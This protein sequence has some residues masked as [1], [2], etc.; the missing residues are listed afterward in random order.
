MRCLSAQAPA[1][2]APLLC[3]LLLTCTPAGAADTLKIE[4]RT[5]VEATAERVRARVVIANGGTAPAYNLRVHLTALGVSDAS[6]VVSRLDPGRMEGVSFKRD[7]RGMPTGRYPMTVRVDFHDANQYPFS[8]LSGMT[9]DVGEPVNPDL[10]VLSRD[11]E[12]QGS[13]ILRFDLKNLGLAPARITAT[14]VLPKELSSPA[15][16]KGFEMGPRSEGSIGFEVRNFSALPGAS[17]PVFSY[18]EYDSEGVHH[19][20]LGRSLITIAPD[21]TLFRR[22]RWAWIALAGILGALLIL[23]LLRGRRQK[24]VG[25]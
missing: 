7:I 8:A 23:V 19:T 17:Y 22:F 10:A 3:W 20:A 18:F 24:A 13:G 6:P 5:D 14:L 4:T 1:F 9:V 15:A 21:D 16:E 11:L 2:L 12:L 25:P